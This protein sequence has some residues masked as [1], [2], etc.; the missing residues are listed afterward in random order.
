M[1][2]PIRLTTLAAVLAVVAAA[3][4]LAGPLPTSAK[5][6]SVNTGLQTLRD[7]NLVVL[8]DLKSSSEVEG[9]AFVGGNLSGNSSNYFTK[10]GALKGGTGL[11]VVGDVT[12]STK[13]INNGAALKVGGNLDSGANMNGG[14]QVYVD[15]NATKLNANGAAVYIDGNVSK[16]NAKDIYYGGSKGSNVNGTLHAGDHTAKGLQDDLEGQLAAITLGVQDASAYFADLDPTSAL[17]YS[18]DKQKAIFDAGTG[19]GVAVFALS[20]LNAA[21]K[22]QSQLQFALPTTY[23]A[24]IVNVAGLK[25]SL[26]GGINFNGPSGLGQKVIWNFYEATSIDLG[27]KSWY[28]SV[29]APYADLKT[30]NFI[31]GSVVARNFAQNGE[32]HMNNWAG[33]LTIKAE[34]LQSAVPEPATW[35]MLIL[36]FGF[37][38]SLLRRRRAATV[39]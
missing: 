29:L 9:R 7:Y 24:V 20:D 3:P 5:A 33:S 26:P 36:G 10:P 2:P 14:G 6:E 37:V 39:A 23:D 30:G 18:P 11:T 13:Q 28:G 22:S 32:I 17:T 15:G 38:G 31:E 27:S 19:A 16:T 35:A 1:S 34:E 12:G 25:V 4:A 8:K 21:L